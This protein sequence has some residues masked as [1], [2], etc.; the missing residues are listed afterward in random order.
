MYS[1]KYSLIYLSL[2]YY[3]LLLKCSLIDI[4]YDANKLSFF[5]YLILFLY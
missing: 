5:N 2:I 3:N 1:I 4:R